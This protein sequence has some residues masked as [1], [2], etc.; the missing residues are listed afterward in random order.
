M[1]KKILIISL[2]ILNLLI[3]IKALS[4]PSQILE[5]TFLDVGQGDSI[6]I[7]FPRKGN[8][9]IDGGSAWREYDSGERVIAPFLRKKG[10]KRVD[11]IVLSHPHLDHVGG[12]IYVIKNFK[13]GLILSN[14]QMHNS[15]TYQK[16]LETV[17]KKNIPY[18]IGR[19]GQK[20]EGYKG[21][22]IYILHPREPLI[23]NTNSDLN[24]NSLVIKLT[25]KKISFLFTGDIEREAESDLL[26]LGEIL[27]STVLKVP[28]QGSRTSSTEEFLEAVKPKIAVISVGKKNRFHHPHSLALKRLKKF[29]IKVYRTDKDGAVIMTTTGER[30]NLKTMN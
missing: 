6:F 7:Q 21:V 11:L 15:Y 25:Y 27:K 10:I 4:P 12:L 8:I 26:R 1:K 30:I 22:E 29:G 19:W 28:H 5:V 9:L 17:K 13:I 3:W 24:N 16:F 14:G 20:I 23:K 18:K 2:L